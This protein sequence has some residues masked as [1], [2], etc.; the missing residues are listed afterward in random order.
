MEEQLSHL[1]LHKMVK[2]GEI[3]ALLCI[4]AEIVFPLI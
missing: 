1:G 4:K 2:S 3:W